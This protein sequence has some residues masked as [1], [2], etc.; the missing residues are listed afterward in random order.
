MKKTLLFLVFAAIIVLSGCKK[1]DPEPSCNITSPKNGAKLL[2][3][4]DIIVSV[5]VEKFKDVLTEMC[6]LM[7]FNVAPR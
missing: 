7:I 1:P 2:I 6:I 5:E 4:E 3:N